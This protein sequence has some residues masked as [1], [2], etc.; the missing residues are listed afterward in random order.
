MYTY[1]ISVTLHLGS[2][3]CRPTCISRING[4]SRRVHWVRTNPCAR[5]S[6]LCK[7]AV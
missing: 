3:V 6:S 1:T 4:G 7:I 5:L 2:V